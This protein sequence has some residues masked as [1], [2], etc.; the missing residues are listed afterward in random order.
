M[1]KDLKNKLASRVV[2]FINEM[3]PQNDRMFTYDKLMPVYEKKLKEY[4]KMVYGSVSNDFT[5]KMFNDLQESI[6]PDNLGES[7]SPAVKEATDGTDKIITSLMILELGSI[8]YEY[9][10][11]RNLNTDSSIDYG[12]KSIRRAIL[13]FYN[14]FNKTDDAPVNRFFNVLGKHIY[15]DS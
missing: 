10:S 5:K 14:N 9:K 8:I 4:S 2:S 13:Y 15:R 3:E 12:R 6:Y 7:I 11:S 1:E